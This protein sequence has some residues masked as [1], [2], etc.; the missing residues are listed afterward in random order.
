MSL[1]VRAKD[2]PSIQLTVDPSH[3]FRGVLKH[4]LKRVGRLSEGWQQTCRLEFDNEPL[5]LNSRV[6]STE[7]EDNDLVRSSRLTM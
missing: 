3:L 2:L 6:N 1:T 7:V 4:Y 5:D